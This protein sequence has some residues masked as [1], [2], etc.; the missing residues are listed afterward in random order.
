MPYR[1]DHRDPIGAYE[2]RKIAVALSYEL[3]G[4]TL[5]KI[6]ATGKGAI[7]ERILALAFA[8]GVKVREDRELAQLLS[9]VELDSEIPTE[10]IMA[11]AEILSYLYRAGELRRAQAKGAE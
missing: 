4:E 6:V 7:A 5:P 9:T 3:G 2:R 10:A 8:N 1:D 11:V